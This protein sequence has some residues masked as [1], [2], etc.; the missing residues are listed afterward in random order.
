MVTAAYSVQILIHALNAQI[1]PFLSLVKDALF[2]VHK[3]IILTL[4]KIFVTNYAHKVH[5]HKIQC[6][7]AWLVCIH[8]RL[9]ALPLDV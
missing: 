6:I 9:A 8:V 5:T 2:N 1:L 3:P 4:Q 7:N